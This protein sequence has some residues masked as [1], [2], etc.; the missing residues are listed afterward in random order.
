[1][2]AVCYTRVSTAQQAEEGVSLE[3]QEVRLR[4]YCVAQGIECVE[5]VTDAAISAGKLPALADRPGGKRVLELLSSGAADHVVALKLD[6]CFRS[7]LECLQ[8]VEL[9]DKQGVTFSFLDLGVNT[10]SPSGKFFLLIIAGVAEMERNLISER[11]KTAMAHLK[12]KG[13]H[14]GHPFKSPDQDDPDTV[15]AALRL[16]SKGSTLREVAVYLN[17]YK[18]PTSS[19]HGEWSAQTVSNLLRRHGS[20]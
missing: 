15:A 20:K 19:G 8:Q 13:V 1:M 6:R 16:R 4:A 12:A 11:T 7:A 5:V 14:C 18:H 17:A 2:K 10:A 9:W 3:A